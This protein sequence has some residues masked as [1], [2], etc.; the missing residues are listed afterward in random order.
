MKNAVIESGKQIPIYVMLRP[1]HDERYVNRGWDGR[2]EMELF[3]GV[4]ADGFVV[5]VLDGGFFF[6]L[7]VLFLLSLSLQLGSVSSQL[8]VARVCF[9]GFGFL[10]S[11]FWVLE[12]SWGS[13]GGG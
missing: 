12:G 6:W 3:K 8:S 10:V 11:G 9:L 5:G 1:E 4:G 7:V 13:Y 2:E